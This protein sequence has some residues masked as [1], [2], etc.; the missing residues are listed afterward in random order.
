MRR[1]NLL[2]LAVAL[3]TSAS[4]CV[5]SSP[6]A[7]P[8]EQGALRVASFDFAESV[9]LAEV[10]A[11]AAERAGVPVERLGPVGPREVLVPAMRN[12]QIDLVPEYVGSA[13]R[14]AGVVETPHDPQVAATLLAERVDEFD[15]DVLMPSSAVD[16]NVVVVSAETAAVHGL[17]AISDL[18]GVRL[19]TFG[20]PPECPDRP[21]CLAGLQST[22]GLTFEEF[23][24]QP[25]LAFT[26]EA[27]RR[28]EI[29]VGVMFSTSPELEAADLVVLADDR[30]LQPPENVVPVV[31]VLALERWDPDLR[32]SLDAVSTNL[33][34]TDLRQMNGQIA[35]G[36]AAVDVARE[37]LATFD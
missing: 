29:D 22:Y 21:L 24:A 16:Q 18:A 28:G 19:E 35:G 27:L 4:A 15:I 8:T 26:A 37:W 34:T 9:V 33:T 6:T 3:L 10:Y 17:V 14:F 11:Q 13:L 1:R 7:E 31:R 20:G 32:R 23:V 12:D 25:T 30:N 5:G 2:A 36:A